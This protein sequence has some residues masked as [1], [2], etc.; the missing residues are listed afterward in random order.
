M[1]YYSEVDKKTLVLLGNA[2]KV[3]DSEKCIMTTIPCEWCYIF[4]N[5]AAQTTNMA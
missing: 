2:G 5:I 1:K 3:L 4:F